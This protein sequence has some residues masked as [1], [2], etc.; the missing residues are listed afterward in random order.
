MAERA[1]PF[2]APV[3]GEATGVRLSTPPRGSLW[4]VACWAEQ[5]D[6]IEKALALECGCA[7]PAPGQIVETKDGRLLIRVEPLKWW[8]IGPD[9]AECPLKPEPDFGAW[10]DMAHDQAT[11]TLTGPNAAEILK[12]M[13]SIDVRDAAFPNMSYA[14]THMHHMI[15][16]VLRID[17]DEPSYQVMVMRSYA[18]DLREITQHHLA[19]FG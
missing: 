5:F 12:R 15:T 1:S 10:L 16:R 11:V 13:V 8:I 18:D 14:T 17:T 19:H 3:M 9:G 6:Q 2:A 4:Q 7:E